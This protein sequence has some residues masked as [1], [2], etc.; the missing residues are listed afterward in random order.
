MQLIDGWPAT[1]ARREILLFSDGYDYLRGDRFSPDVQL[2]V[3]KAQQAGIVIHAIYSAS[4]GRAG[5]SRRVVSVGQGNLNQLTDGTGGY[6]TFASDYARANTAPLSASPYLSQLN[7]ILKNQYFLTFATNRSK[8]GKGEY[9]GI[10]VLTE[11]RDAE[12]K[13]AD[14]VFIPGSGK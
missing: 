4:A 11:R 10:K 5:F 9:R 13:A 2:T 1:G 7:L 6:V 3:D 12:L 8:N 14:K